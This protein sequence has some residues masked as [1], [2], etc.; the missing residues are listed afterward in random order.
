MKLSHK[1]WILDK[2]L[3]T[4]ERKRRQVSSWVMTYL[5]YLNL[6]MPLNHSFRIPL[7]FPLP[8]SF[9]DGCERAM[10]SAI[11]PYSHVDSPSLSCVFVAKYSPKQ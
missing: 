10:V 9:T 6:E 8:F 5:K 2:S 1:V 4:F 3:L 11:R 7:M